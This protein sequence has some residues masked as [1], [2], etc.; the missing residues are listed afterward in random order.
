MH[1]PMRQPNVFTDYPSPET[2]A[3]CRQPI[4]TGGLLVTCCTIMSSSPILAS[5]AYTID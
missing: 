1:G 3:T 5:S 4:S 2:E